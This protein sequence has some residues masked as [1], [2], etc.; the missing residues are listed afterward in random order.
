MQDIV[1]RPTFLPALVWV[2]TA[3]R[4]A[5][6]LDLVPVQGTPAPSLKVALIEVMPRG[7][8]ASRPRRVQSVPLS[9]PDAA[10]VRVG[11][12][13][14]PAGRLCALLVTGEGCRRAGLTVRVRQVGPAV[15]DPLAAPLAGVED[16][17]PFR[18]L[19]PLPGGGPVSVAK[20]PLIAAIAGAE[21]LSDLEPDACVARLSPVDWAAQIEARRPDLLLVEA[22]WPDGLG[23]WRLRR[24]DGAPS[25][26]L[27]GVLAACRA[28]HIPTVLWTLLEPA[29][30]AAFRGVAGQFDHV[31]AADAATAT[32]LGEAVP[33]V[34]RGHL[35][36]GIQPAVHNPGRPASAAGDFGR[37]AVLFDGWSDALDLDGVR[38][39]LRTVAAGGPGRPL[40]VVESRY[41]LR[42]SRIADLPDLRGHV[43]GCVDGAEMPALLHRHAAA[44]FLG[45]GLRAEA[46]R[47]RDMLRAVACGAVPVVDRLESVPAPVRDCAVPLD[48]L[49]EVDTPEV[50]LRLRRAQREILRGHTM[51]DRLATICAAAGV[52][53]PRE[54]PKIS[55]LTITRR[56]HML[57][58]ARRM[59]EA[60]TWPDREWLIVVNDRDADMARI[61]ESVAGLP[62]VR[63]LHLGQGN[64]IGACLNAAISEAEGAMWAKMD[65]DDLYG[66]H[67]LEDVGTP[68]WRF[69]AQVSGKPP[70]FKL[71]ESDGWVYQD[72]GHPAPLSTWAAHWQD[73]AEARPS[74]AGATLS[75]LRGDPRVPAF[76]EDWRGSVDSLFVRDALD[77]GCRIYADAPVNFVVV[78][79]RDKTKHVWRMPD[80]SV[81]RNGRRLF[82]LSDEP[83]N[84]F[85]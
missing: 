67:Y 69:G 76:R 16:L 21:L 65:D 59:L 26:E 43:L 51:A 47:H 53:F 24:G 42:Q 61:R 5:Y 46:I 25:P 19:A 18:L 13:R 39:A 40:H 73:A 8:T 36:L 58:S 45:G 32:A 37:E 72:T 68:L 57:A 17:T 48:A 49:A 23:G 85:C 29:D 77:N 70:T 82:R 75:A 1:R 80:A 9:E 27:E 33:A 50:F 7:G 10:G 83:M 35:P 79:Q 2:K 74:I 54:R 52:P 71:L 44:L 56:P 55:A 81:I 41:R 64:A 14:A 28:R 11:S 34:A 66:P 6:R 22:G 15:P 62:W 38:A 78:R 84:V 60:Q 3:C 20:G 30:D 12:F 4:A 63:V 31:F